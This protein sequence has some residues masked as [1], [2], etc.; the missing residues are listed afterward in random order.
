MACTESF[1]SIIQL[2]LHLCLKRLKR[3]WRA[4][5]QTLEKLIGREGGVGQWGAVPA[6]AQYC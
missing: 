6:N 1:I 2:N 3:H 5:R 4:P